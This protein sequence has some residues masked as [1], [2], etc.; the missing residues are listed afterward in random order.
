MRV[1]GAGCVCSKKK[2]AMGG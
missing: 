1:T 2:I